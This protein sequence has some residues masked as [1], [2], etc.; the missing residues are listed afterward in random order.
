MSC[1]SPADGTLLVV[2]WP[3]NIVTR[4]PF[5]DDALLPASWRVGSLSLAVSASRDHN[6]IAGRAA[7]LVHEHE[8]QEPEN[9]SVVGHRV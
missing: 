7:L 4:L 8:R 1:S 6:V 9:E 3:E 5:L 2:G